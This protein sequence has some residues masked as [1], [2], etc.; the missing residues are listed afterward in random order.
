MTERIS[1]GRLQVAAVLHRLV[2]E[3]I[4]PG[5]GVA[6]KAFWSALESIVEELGPRLHA[7]LQKRDELQAKLDDWCHRLAGA[8]PEPAITKDFLIEIGYLVPEGE[9]F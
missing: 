2:S 4:A 6:P 7:L 9:D 3:R 8:V 1:E 5:T